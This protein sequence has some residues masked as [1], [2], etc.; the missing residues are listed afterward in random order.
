MRGL[1]TVLILPAERRLALGLALGQ[2]HRPRQVLGQLG[3]RGSTP[4]LSHRWFKKL[5]V[6]HSQQLP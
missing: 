4:S 3:P 1:Q 5:N 6:L 2:R